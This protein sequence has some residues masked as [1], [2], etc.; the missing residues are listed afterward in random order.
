MAG[1]GKG[2]D[3]SPVELEKSEEPRY[4]DLE[5]LLELGPAHLALL[6]GMD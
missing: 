1:H 5:R 2:P 3:I 4:S 6:I